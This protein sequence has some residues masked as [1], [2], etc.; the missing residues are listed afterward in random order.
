MEYVTLK[1]AVFDIDI[2]SQLVVFF[3]TLK[4]NVPLGSEL[5]ESTI[6]WTQRWKIKVVC[7]SKLSNFL[8]RYAS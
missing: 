1:N 5:G 3:R 7:A 4:V 6:K 8:F 2:A